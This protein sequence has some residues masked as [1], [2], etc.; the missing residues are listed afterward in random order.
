MGSVANTVEVAQ[1]LCFIALTMTRP[2]TAMMITT[3]ISVPM[4]AAVPPTGPS[5]SRAIWPRLRPSRRA[6]MNRMIMSCTQPPSTAPTMIHM[7]PGR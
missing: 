1:G 2:S 7:V 3:I 4:T 5:S 6:D